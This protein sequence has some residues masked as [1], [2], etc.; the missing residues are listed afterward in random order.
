M[1]RPYIVGLTGQSGSGK[2]TVSSE[3]EQNGFYVINC[4]KMTHI[5]LQPDTDCC[6]ALKEKYPQFFDGNVFN[7]RKAASLLFSDSQLLESY[8]STIFPFINAEISRRIEEAWA[9][10]NELILLDAPTLFEAGAEKLCDTVVSCI[11]DIDV[12][13]ERI[14]RRDG[15]SKQDALKRF[16]SQHDESFFIERSDHIIENNGSIENTKKAAERIT[17]EIKEK[18]N[19]N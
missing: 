13:T 16:S 19:G 7:R 18:V 14:I 2:S 5:L 15:I 17:K 3:F 10:G 4:D 1:N 8:N 9:S 11:A 12:R 6:K